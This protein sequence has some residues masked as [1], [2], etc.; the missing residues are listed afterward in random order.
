[1]GLFDKKN[2]DICGEKIGIMGNRKLDNGNL[3]KKCAGKLSPWF[4]ERR[5]ST[6]DDIKEQLAYREENKNAVRNFKITREFS[7]DRYHVFIDDNKGMFAV[8]FNMSEQ[9]N[10]DI[11]PLS[12][13]TLCRLEIDEQ[14][15]EEEYTDQDGETRSYVPPRYTYSYDYKIKL[16]VNTPWF[17]DMDFQLNTFSVEDRERAKM[18]KY[19][20]LGNQIVSALTGVPVPAYEGMMNQGYPQQGGMMNQGYPQQ[21]GMMN[22]GYPQQGGTMNPGIPAAGRNDESGISAAGRNDESG[23]P[24][25]GRND[26][27]GIPAAGRNDESGISTAGRNDES[28]IP[29]AG[30]NDESGISAAGRNDESGMLTAG[31]R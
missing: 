3:C 29:A 23:I 24:A 19:E 18:M 16:S 6:V 13:I 15:E 8:A 17:D 10:P 11:V 1:M 14:R 7:G 22:Q 26:E 9:N 20:Q 31:S 2:C 12:A 27:S 28:G 30:R 5:H 4:E 21:G 25:A